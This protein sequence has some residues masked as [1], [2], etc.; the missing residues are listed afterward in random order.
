MSTR[1]NILLVEMGNHLWMYHHWDGYSSWLGKKLMEKMEKHQK[2][3]A[4][5]FD[6]AN[7]LIK[8]KDDDAYEIT[9]RRHGD[10]EYLYVINITDRSIECIKTSFST[11]YNDKNLLKVQYNE[12]EDVKKWYD[13]CKKDEVE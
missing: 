6:I 9:P 3:Y 1:A 10:I 5:I 12:T 4:D 8:D 2:D 13:F 11:E 7:E